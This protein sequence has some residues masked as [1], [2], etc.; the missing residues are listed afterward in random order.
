MADF[1]EP[2]AFAFGDLNP[3]SAGRAAPK[4]N[5]KDISVM[6]AIR[7]VIIGYYKADT[8]AGTGPYKGVVL[9][10]EEDMDQN[11]SLIHISEPTR[12]Y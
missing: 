6:D 12:P 7:E 10:V 3:V 4:F 2:K 11:L 8:L 1:E 5:P 9:R